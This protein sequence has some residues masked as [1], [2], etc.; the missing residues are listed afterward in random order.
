MW[1][2]LLRWAVLVIVTA[3]LA[4]HVSELFDHWDHTLRTGREAD[5]TLVVLAACAGLEIVIAGSLLRFLGLFARPA[6]CSVRRRPALTET[7]FAETA[8]AGPSPPLLLSFR[9]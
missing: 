8:P 9:I 3:M 6:R 5:Y 4:G 7:G 1:G 2:K